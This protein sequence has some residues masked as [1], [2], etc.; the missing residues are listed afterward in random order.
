[1]GPGGSAAGR[2]EE[3]PRLATERLWLR[4]WTLAEGDVR[5][6]FAIFGDPEVTR[7]LTRHELDLDGQR[8]GLAHLIADSRS[9]PAGLGWFALERRSDGGVIGC[10][11][12]KPLEGSDPEVE[13]G[14]HVARAHW[15]QGYATEAARGLLRHGFETLGLA[16]IVAVVDPRNARSLAVVARLGMRPEGA[17]LRHGRECLRFVQEA[18][19]QGLS[20][21]APRPKPDPGR[22]LRPS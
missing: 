8:L 17:I 21:P 19:T 18:P 13:V 12:L 14:Y 7:Y 11:A 1:L 15:G 9:Y 4:P 3:G 6:A 22:R 10:G 20:A 16:R 5:G 2:S